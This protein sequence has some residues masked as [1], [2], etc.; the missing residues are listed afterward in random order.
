MPNETPIETQTLLRR[1]TISESV[2]NDVKI[3]CDNL[4]AAG[5]LVRGCFQYQDQLIVIYQLTR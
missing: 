3:E 1:F 2:E 4:G 5:Y